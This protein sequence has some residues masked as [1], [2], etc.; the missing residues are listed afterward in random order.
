MLKLQSMFACVADFFETKCFFFEI[1]K[2]K[3]TSGL[4][5]TKFRT[6]H[7]KNFGKGVKLSWKLGVQKIILLN[8]I[9]LFWE[10]IINSDSFS[11]F[12]LKVLDFLWR[13]SSIRVVKIVLY[14]SGWA[15]EKTTC[16]SS[17]QFCFHISQSSDKNFSVRLSKMHSA[18]PEERCEDFL[19]IKLF[20]HLLSLFERNEFWLLTKFFRHV[21]QNCI[22]HFQ[23]KILRLFSQ[24][25]ILLEPF[26]DLLRKPFGFSEEIFRHGVG[27]SNVLCTCPE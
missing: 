15:F 14:M 21:F 13:R 27:F 18:C 4:R 26:A 2:F 11:D 1:Y 24:K 8:Q 5:A 19:T 20:L 23:R 22:L 9:T 10:K 3:L 7:K 16:F 25:I 17:K 12:V 6:L